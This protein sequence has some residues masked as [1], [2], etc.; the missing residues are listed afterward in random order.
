MGK[1]ALVAVSLFD[2]TLWWLWFLVVCMGAVTC[3]FWNIFS[4]PDLVK[5]LLVARAKGGIYR[6]CM[7]APQS[8]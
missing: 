7:R 2:L 4:G 6:K 3:T 8:T 5:A 1:L